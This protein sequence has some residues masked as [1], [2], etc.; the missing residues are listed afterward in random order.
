MCQLGSPLARSLRSFK[1]AAMSQSMDAYACGMVV[2]DW[3]SLWAITRRTFVAG[4]SVKVPCRN[5]MRRLERGEIR[6]YVTGK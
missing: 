4:T 6:V 5:E 3:V 2:F 1:T